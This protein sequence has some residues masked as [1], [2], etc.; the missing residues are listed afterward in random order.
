LAFSPD[1]SLLALH[2]FSV[3][4]PGVIVWDL[5]SREV[6]KTL[7]SGRGIVPYRPRGPTI[8]FSPDGSTLAAISAAVG[9]QLRGDTVSLWDT[10]TWDERAH[11]QPDEL[12]GSLAFS[13]DG[14]LIAVAYRAQVEPQS[15]RDD[16][17]RLAAELWDAQA[18]RR[19]VPLWL[20]PGREYRGMTHS[21]YRG[22]EISFSHDGELLAT[23]GSETVHVWRVESQ[24]CLGT[25]DLEQELADVDGGR[26]FAQLTPLQK[27]AARV[28]GAFVSFSP[29]EDKLA[30]AYRD[31]VW[32][33]ELAKL[34]DRLKPLP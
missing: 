23:G 19:V 13:P 20:P 14:R 25:L 15:D 21:A 3:A 17:R 30:T 5:K 10:T 34:L 28:V 31:T 32:V 27:R 2:C 24:T 33:W 12:P 11:F 1:E 29:T 18:V 7:S 16:P 22:L 6:H 4:P 8:A 26:K 9:S